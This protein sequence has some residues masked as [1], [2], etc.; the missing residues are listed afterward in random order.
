MH[1]LTDRTGGDLQVLYKYLV[2]E[3]RNWDMISDYC[4]FIY[5][6]HHEREFVEYVKSI[7]FP[8]VTLRQVWGRE[9]GRTNVE[10]ILQY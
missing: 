6:I 2:D 5:Y 7:N 3:N 10:M 1:H 8:H 9:R 4:V